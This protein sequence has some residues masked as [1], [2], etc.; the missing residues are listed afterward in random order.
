MK[1]LTESIRS[2][3]R[4]SDF[5]HLLAGLS[6]TGLLLV[7]LFR[8]WNF[9]PHIPIQY[10]GDGL[11]SLMS[12]QN[13]KQAFWYLEST[14]LGFPFHQNL[15]DFPA[16][17]DTTNLLFS[18]LLISLTGDINLTFNI[19]YL[20]SYFSAFLGAYIGSR[21]IR[22]SPIHAV[23]IGLI[24]AF[25]PFHFLHGSSHL[26]LSSYW[27]IPIW[28]SV[29]VK[30]IS[31]PG[32]ILGFEGQTKLSLGQCAVKKRTL[33]LLLLTIISASA[34][35]YYSVFFIFATG[36]FGLLAII[37]ERSARNVGLLLMGSIGSVVAGLQI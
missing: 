24:Y 10:S 19:Q 23:C 7:Y 21:I 13:M 8:L 12:F 27:M 18:R 32:W 16:V 33:L 25:L 29:I 30:E 31:D 28:L 14:H 36:F 3:C 35:F 11:L 20:I 15:N 34:G 4:N 5:R 1:S 22:L 2:I 17:A 37:R 6:L 9:N 26:Y